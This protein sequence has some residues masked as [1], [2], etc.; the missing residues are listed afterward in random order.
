MD[1]AKR[2][3]YTPKKHKNKPVSP[4]QIEKKLC[5]DCLKHGKEVYLSKTT[6]QFRSLKDTKKKER[7]CPVL[8]CLYCKYVERIESEIQKIPK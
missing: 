4:D 6:K 8:F 5:P 3:R 7:V 1:T 2:S